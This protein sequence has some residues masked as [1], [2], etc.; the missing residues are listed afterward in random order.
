M[1]EFRGFKL[2]KR[3][4]QASKWIA[5]KSRIRPKY[6]RL[7]PPPPPATSS[8]PKLKHISKLITWGQRLTCGAKT[9]CCSRPGSNYI[10]LGLDPV[11]EKKVTVPKGHL[12]VY[13]GQEDGDFR[14]VLVPVIYFNHPLFGE[15]LREAEEKYGFQHEGGITI[16]CRMAEF[17]RVQTRIAAGSGGS[18]RLTWKRHH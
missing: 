4:V 18:R 12:A 5:L 2:G 16:P 11:Q 14:R 7:N 8:K 6:H 3:L 1:R 10:P 13:V 17:E 9:L 15:L